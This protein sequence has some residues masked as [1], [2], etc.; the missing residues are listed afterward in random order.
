MNTPRIYLL[1]DDVL[2]I[3][4]LSLILEQEG[5]QIAGSARSGEAALAQIPGLQPDLVLVDIDLSM[6]EGKLDG[7]D[8]I[9]QL[10]ATYSVPCIF[11]TAQK[12]GLTLRKSLQS[13]AIGFINKPFVKSEVIFAIERALKQAESVD[14]SPPSSQPDYLLIPQGTR[15][16]KVLISDIYYL[17]AANQYLS[18]HLHSGK[19]YVASLSLGQFEKQYLTHDLIRISREHI[20]NL[21]Y[22]TGFEAPARLLL[23]KESF[24]VGKTYRKAVKKRLPFL[25]G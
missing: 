18:I 16:I 10:H 2:T 11:L 4:N 19:Q 14:S 20:V 3:E 25:R 22:L 8:T 5:F 15:H 1:E 13:E 9:R 21:K 23:G 6:G 12:D 7:I 17:T 24:E